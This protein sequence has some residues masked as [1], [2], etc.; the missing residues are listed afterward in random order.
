MDNLQLFKNKRVY[1]RSELMERKMSAEIHTYW[2]G[3]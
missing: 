1:S 3:G 2:W